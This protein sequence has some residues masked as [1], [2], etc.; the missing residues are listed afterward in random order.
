MLELS[1]LS[2]SLDTDFSLHSEELKDLASQAL[3]VPKS[4]LVRVV[5]LKRSVDARKKKN[6]HFIATLG[7][8]LQSSATEQEL[9][10][11]GVEAPLNLK[12][13]KNYVPL[14]IPQHNAGDAQETRPVV[15]GMGPAGLFAALYLAKAGKRPLVIEQGKAVEQRLADVEAF[16]QGAN[17]NLSSNIQFGEGG[18]GTFSDG[19][20]TTNTKNPYTAHVLRWFVEAGAPEEIMWQ[21]KPHIGTDRLVEVVRAIRQEIIALGGEVRFETQLVGM[22]F[23][24]GKLCNIELESTQAVS[25]G[26]SPKR[27]KL[28]ANELILAAGHSARDTFSLLHEKGLPLEQKPFSVGVRIEH[29]QEEINRAQ[30][31]EAADH[32]ALDAA[33]YKLAVHLDSGRSVYTFCMCPGGEVVCAASEAETVVVNGMSRFARDAQNANAAVLVSVDPKDFASEHPLAGVD[34]QREIESS[35]FHE[36]IAAGGAA[37]QAPAQR[38]GSFLSG[39]S[40]RKG[41]DKGPR[42]SYA[43]GVVY[44]DLHACLPAFVT[45]ALKEAFPLFDRKLKGFANPNA[46]LTGVETRSSSPVRICRKDNF[47][48]ELV[49]GV[50]SGFYPC[51]EGAGYAGGIMSAAVDGLRVAEYITASHS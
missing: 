26:A 24:E 17:L 6:V 1:N 4:D 23:D 42:P 25:A 20:L 51:G 15:V 41:N 49:S 14:Q 28:A 13:H 9:L 2:L 22:R 50:E 27:E 21:A 12:K 38:V 43:R 29:T 39:S 33:D 11:R 37:Y 48:S 47:Q 36:A 16:N 40:A 3:N 30:Y 31:G 44:C 8:E 32:P 45:E 35:A 10:S 46:V 7:L 18:A 34:F 19:K 5:L